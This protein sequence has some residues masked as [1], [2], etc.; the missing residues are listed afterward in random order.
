MLR[1]EPRQHLGR[2]PLEDGQLPLVER[3]VDLDLVHAELDDATDHVLEAIDGL[4]AD[5][6][7]AARSRRGIEHQVGPSQGRRIAPDGRAGVGHRRHPPSRL[8]IWASNNS[9]NDMLFHVS[10]RRAAWRIMT[11]PRAA[12]VSG[13]RGAW[14]GRGFIAASSDVV[15]PAAERGHLVAQQPVD[16]LEVLAEPGHALGGF[17]IGHADHRV[18]RVE[19]GPGP[20][21][22]LEPAARHVVEGQRL[23]REHRRDCAARSGSPTSPA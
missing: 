9:R 8:A 12:T 1:S 14:T 20:E 19:R 15:E 21:P 2:D 7:A 11:G 16:D 18:R 3:V 4:V 23:A 10:A 5:H 13:G 6:R 17:P 22:D